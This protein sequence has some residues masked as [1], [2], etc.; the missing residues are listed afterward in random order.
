MTQ[1][2]ASP[3]ASLALLAPMILIVASFAAYHLVTKTLRA[4]IPPFVF[5]CAV[6]A[7]SLAA[8]AV[9]ALTGASQTA[10]PS[11]GLAWRD[12]VPVAVLGLALVGI[13]AG[14][15]LAYRAGWPVSLAPTIANVSVAVV[16]LPV[17]VLML[18]ETLSGLNLAGLALAVAG[19]A[20]MAHRS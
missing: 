3:A 11:A 14:F 7:V 16:L 2:P 20:L 19:L 4:D 13:E 12:L 10:A 6:Y 1:L 18:R 9:L 15:I 8:S 17:A 5:L